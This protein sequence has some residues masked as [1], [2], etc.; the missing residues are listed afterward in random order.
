MKIET[1]DSSDRVLVIAEIG[2]N[3]EGD[4]S[5]AEELIAR[6]SA[7]GVDAVKFQYIDPE[8]LVPPEQN[9]RL[10]QLARFRLTDDEFVQLR[11]VADRENVLFLCTP[12]AIDAVEFLEPLVPAYKVASGDLT[13]LPLLRSIARTKKPVLLSTGMSDLNEID[14]SVGVVR[15]AWGGSGSGVALLHCVSAYPTPAEEAHLSAI[16]DLVPLADAVGYSDHTIG[17]DASVLAVA[18]GA[19]IVE[20]HFTL[21][22]DFSDFRDHQLSAD[23]RDMAALVDRIRE[24][25]SMLGNGPKRPLD[26]EVPL[27]EATRRSIAAASD[28]SSGHVISERDLT[29]LRQPGDY[30]PGDEAALIGRTLSRPM[31]SGEPFLE[32]C[33]A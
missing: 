32:T 14:R 3:H 10:E 24:A 31:A 7:A 11:G 23:P 13:F 6:A 28:L 25:E 16:R 26:I 5:V 27:R 15:E 29:W 20:K 2:N 21:N 4:Y 18:A 9:A 17:I 30:S 12:F 22:K 33:I 8:A 19:R 1:W